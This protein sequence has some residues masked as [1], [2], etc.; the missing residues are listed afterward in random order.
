[1][2]DVKTSRRLA[3][4][5]DLLTQN[6]AGTLV[7][8]ANGDALGTATRSHGYARY[9][10]DWNSGNYPSVLVFRKGHPPVVFAPNIFLKFFAERY[11]KHLNVIYSKPASLGIDVSNYLMSL[12]ERGDRIAF[13]GRSETPQP[14]WANL[15]DNVHCLEFFDFESEIDQLRIEKHPDEI[16][17]HRTAGSICDRL[18]ESAFKSARTG[19]PVYQIRA[20]LQRD[21]LYE[22]CD[23]ASTWIASAPVADYSRSM[24]EE[25]QQTPEEGDQFLVGAMVLYRGCW[26]HGIRTA[27]L[28]YPNDKQ[29]HVFS[30]VSSMHTRMLE[31]MVVNSEIGAVQEAAQ[32]T[33]NDFIVPEDETF[34]FRFGHPLGYSY[35]DP[36][37]QRAEP[38]PQHYEGGAPYRA[39]VPLRENMIFE[40][41]PNV[42]IK[43]AA[44]AAIGDMV[45]LTKSGYELLTNYP[46]GLTIL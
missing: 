31:R 35:E 22:G 3:E 28:G 24:L 7:V 27:N 19:K 32:S 39:D 37:P 44:G 45:L 2:P 43:G 29:T 14:F 46:R 5:F 10:A 34:R 15:V 8:Y 36:L 11:A 38:F 20:D 13:V 25:C 1:M 21:A 17:L 40:L 41:H 12:H 4:V 16:E 23:Y 33:L 6:G 42:F 9:L 30:A 26:G 18:F